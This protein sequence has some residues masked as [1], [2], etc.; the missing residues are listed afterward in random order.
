MKRLIYLSMVSL[1][2][3]GAVSCKKSE[4]TKNSI[5]IDG[6]SYTTEANVSKSGLQ[7]GAYI[8]YF[9]GTG[10]ALFL[11]CSASYDGKKIDLTKKEETDGLGWSIEGAL[12]GKQLF[13][14]SSRNGWGS[15]GRFKAGTLRVK[16]GK[17]G[18][19]SVDFNI[20]LEGGKITDTN[21]NKDHTIEMNI[22]GPIGL[23]NG[24][25]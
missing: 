19:S 7:N 23:V 2:M 8:I 12:G 24:F 11:N 1:I 14:V 18:D 21:D 17:E 22:N 20:V 13:S 16:K 10:G 3:L 4:I 15:N 25:E 6:V 9:S 5:I